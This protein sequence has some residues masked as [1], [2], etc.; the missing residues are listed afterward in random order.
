MK[1]AY[2]VQKLRHFYGRKQVLNIDELTI[3]RHKIVGLVGPNGSGKSTLLRLLAFVESPSDG[4]ITYFPVL[5]T[6]G[7]PLRFQITLLC[8]EPY[9]LKRTVFANIAYGLKIRKDTRNLHDRVAE[10]LEW[11]GLDYSSFAKRKWYELSGG[12]AQRV[13][14][15][16][17]LIL[18][19]SVLLLDEPTASVD[20]ESAQ[21]IRDAILMAKSEWGATIVISSHDR[22]WLYES[23]DQLVHLLR[24][25][26]IGSAAENI[27]F[28]PWKWLNGTLW[29]KLLDGNQ[30]LILK[31]AE[32]E[33]SVAL[34]SPDSLIVRPLSEN[35]NFFDAEKTQREVCYINGIVS[36]LIMERATNN[37]LVSIAVGHITFN[38]RLA[39]NH[40]MLYPGQKV[41][42]EIPTDSARWVS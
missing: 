40:Q 11:V 18:K 25:H 16:A 14:L 22:N 10:A 24:G 31:G 2:L 3:E 30:R 17:R 35:F 13:A 7:R 29:Y 37:I 26:I 19:P 15:A 41:I 20:V 36:A 21:R 39:S 42:L 8:Q 33:N 32:N 12:E 34:L 38:A 28:G 4:K 6:D 1:P 27:V 5:E 9:L 23:C